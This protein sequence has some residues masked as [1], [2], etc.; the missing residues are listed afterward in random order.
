MSSKVATYL[1]SHLAGEVVARADVRERLGRDFGVLEITPELAVYPRTTNDVRKVARFSWQL[2]EKG[3]VL[4]ITARGAGAGTSGGALGKGVALV[5]TAHMNR[6]FEYDSKQYLV[7]V[8][9]GVSLGALSQALGLHGAWVPQFTGRYPVGTIGGMIGDG[10]EGIYA[11]KYGRLGGAVDK[12]EVVL[13]NGDVLQTGRVSKRDLNKKKGLQGLEGDIYRGVDAILEDYADVFESLRVDDATGYNAIADI[14]QK[15]GSIDLTPLFIGSQG[16]LGVVTEMILKTGLRNTKIA[17]AALVFNAAEDAR[18]ALDPLCDLKP[19]FVEYFDARLFKTAEKRGKA[20][21]FYKE[22]SHSSST[23]AIVLIGF[24]DF[25][26][27]QRNKSL[28]KA[29]KIAEKTHGEIVTRSGED[30]LDVLAA[31]DVATYSSDPDSKNESAPNIFDGFQVP[32]ERL[33]D[34]MKGLAELEHK[35]RIDLPISGH[36]HTGVY[37][38]HPAFQLSKVGDKQKILKL[39]E[40][41]TKVVVAYGGSIISGSGEGR[42]KSHFAYAH[43][44]DRLKEMHAAIRKVFDPLGTLNPG[45]KQDTDMRKLAEMLHGGYGPAENARF[46]G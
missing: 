45:V 9:P 1:R 4:P 29:A 33:E 43:L 31:L 16:T 44:D 39:L 28:K 19:M 7:R 6:V 37:S 46:G 13:A 11:G 36:A 18:D 26:E 15:D 12:L 40:E 35:L 32:A 8:Q 23:E 24:D 34:F 25:N 42:L 27:R 41:L 3:H 21:G 38:V 14:K 30:A 20:Y 5:T 10:V 2:A 17:A 22:V